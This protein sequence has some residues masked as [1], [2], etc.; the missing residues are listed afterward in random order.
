MSLTSEQ[1]QVV[2]LRFFFN[3]ST[4]D[5][6]CLMGKTEGAVKALQFRALERLRRG[7]TP[8]LARS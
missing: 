6:A 5:V 8:D 1:R 7:L 2:G 3:L 4:Q